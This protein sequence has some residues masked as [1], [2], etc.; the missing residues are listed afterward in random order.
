MPHGVDIE[1]AAGCLLQGMTAHYLAVSVHAVQPGE[2]CWCTPRRG[3]WALL[4]QLAT[5][6]GGRVI[7]D[8]VHC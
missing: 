3:R 5:A 6:L 1:I 8:G 4:T 2:T 7:G